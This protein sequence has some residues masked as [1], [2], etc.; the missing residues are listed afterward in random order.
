[1]FWVLLSPFRASQVVL[2]IKHPPANA[3]IVRNVGSIPGW[4]R[5]PGERHGNPLQ[6]S[7]LENPMDRGAWWAIVHSV[8]KSRMQWKWLK[9]HANPFNFWFNDNKNTAIC[10]ETKKSVWDLDSVWAYARNLTLESARRNNQVPLVIQFQPLLWPHP[11]KVPYQMILQFT[12]Q[13]GMLLKIRLEKRAHHGCLE[14]MGTW[15]CSSHKFLWG[16]GPVQSLASRTQAPAPSAVT[17]CCPWST[18]LKI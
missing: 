16:Y 2:V 3:G 6:Y 8:A 1:M 12:I 15:S 18:G 17:H 11:G 9:M 5:S 13:T 7:R 14:E 10:T 4:G